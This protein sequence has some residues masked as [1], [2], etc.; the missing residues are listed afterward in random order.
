VKKR[1]YIVDE[2]HMLS[3]PAFN[4]LLKI[5]EEPPEHLM[6]ILATTELHK[7]PATILSRCQR[8]SFKR[9]QPED[10]SHRLG[11]VAE[12]E[13]IDLTE[14]GSALLARL[15]DGALRD[16]LSLL[17]QCAAQGGTVDQ[18]RVLD[19]LGLAGNLKTAHL[20]NAIRRN[21]AASALTLLS[22]LYSAGKDVK[23]VLGEL[24]SL[25]RDLLVQA[26]APKGGQALLTGGYDSATMQTLSKHFPTH[27]LVR[28]LSLLQDTQ[29]KLKNS[30]NPR[31]DAE[32][33]LIR[34]CD[35]SLDGSTDGLA[36][37]ISRLEEMMRNGVAIAAPSDAAVQTVSPVQE[38]SEVQEAPIS[39]ELP[40]PTE[41]LPPWDDV[42]PPPDDRDAP[43]PDDW[44]PP[45]PVPKPAA[46]KS[47]P[48]APPKKQTLSTPQPVTMA[49]DALGKLWPGVA[50]GMKAKLK[51]PASI[52]ITNPRFVSG[53][54]EGSQLILYVNDVTSKKVLDTSEVLKLASK[55]ASEQSGLTLTAKVK[56]GKPAA[57]APLPQAEEETPPQ[58]ETYPGLDPDDKLNDLLAFGKQIGNMTIK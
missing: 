48:S 36:A 47:P 33:C 25:T 1:V 28:V 20:M 5:L 50:Q 2:V 11:Y 35:D 3:T 51:P 18:Q 26:A 10:I 37:R 16:A 30:A 6:F 12:Q 40:P 55:L 46:V 23:A 31:M 34:L 29:A 13:N 58:R 14:D 19:T 41:D 38:V 53:V 43:P 17:D 49:A 8:F 32:L 24:S 57:A 4:A 21:D 7:V 15:S 27:R 39:E 44:I 56:I 54:V 42:P 45:D 9:I 22:E 52:Y